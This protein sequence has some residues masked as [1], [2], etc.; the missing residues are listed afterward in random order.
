MKD[1]RLTWGVQD[2]MPAFL[3]IK[4]S[5]GVYWK[6][7]NIK[8]LLLFPFLIWISDCLSSPVYY[9]ELLS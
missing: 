6:E 8:N 9:R 5:F 3:A 1:F 7:Y 2:D 4:V